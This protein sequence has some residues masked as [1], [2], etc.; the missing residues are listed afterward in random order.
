MGFI[1]DVDQ[2]VTY[3]YSPARKPQNG[4]Q[5]IDR[6]MPAGVRKHIREVKAGEDLSHL[7]LVVL[8]WMFQ[9]DLVTVSKRGLNKG[10]TV[11][12]SLGAAGTQH[13]SEKNGREK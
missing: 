5:E 2:G 4:A 11:L 7:P 12:S 6:L 10:S 9:N 1:P 3:L 8:D 13:K